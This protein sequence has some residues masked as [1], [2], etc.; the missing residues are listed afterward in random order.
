[1]A[2][3]GQAGF[4]LKSPEGLLMAVDPY[5][6]NSC[7]A[8]GKEAG[9]NM[10]RQ[11]PTPLFPQE[12]APFDVLAFT[13]SHQDHV[14]P[15]TI[16]PYLGTSG[17][18]VIVAPHEAFDRL[19]SLGVEEKRMLLTWPN[20]THERGDFI[21]R[22]TFAIPLDGGD[23]THVGYLVEVSNGPRIYFTGDTDYNEILPISVA[24]YQPDIMVTVINPAFRNLS[25]R[26][27]ARLAKSLGPRWVIPCHHDLFPDNCLPDR[28][29]QT[30][31]TLQGMSDTFCPLAHGEIRIFTI[32]SDKKQKAIPLR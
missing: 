1:M 28:L 21:L 31:L 16:G 26:E 22:A 12:L 9:F 24:P 3:L 15:D 13:H 18:G 10:S 8:L 5:L 25:P 11:F 23:L 27:A 14:D 17:N 30:N 2:W 19:S 6:S 7:E 32:P 20:K 29:L 4:A